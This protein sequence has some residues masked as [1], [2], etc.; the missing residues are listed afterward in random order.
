[1]V[2]FLTKP[3]IPL[4]IQ[5][6]TTR[7]LMLYLVA[8][9]HMLMSR[10]GLPLFENKFNLEHFLAK[11]EDLFTIQASNSHQSLLLSDTSTLKWLISNINQRPLLNGWIPLEFVFKSAEKKI[12][13]LPNICTVYFP[14][15]LA[16][17]ADMKT[18][19][20]S[21]N[22]TDLEFLPINVAGVEWI[23][24]NCLKT[25]HQFDEKKS[26]ILRGLNGEIFMI[27]KLFVTDHA[28][29][30]SEV[31]ML[32]DS[33]RTQL[34]FRSSMKDRFDQIGSDGITVQKIGEIIS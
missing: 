21:F 17:R 14:G 5:I 23:L 26:Q 30:G 1:M 20:F 10:I 8:R 12:S 4:F 22:C 6:R 16:F 13:R 9:R 2:F 27:T 31:F 29:G 34:F 18:L 19:L 24:L 28:C 15:L 7:Q 32:A 11:M 33:N 25:V 3:C